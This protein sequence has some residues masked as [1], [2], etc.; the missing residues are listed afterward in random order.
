MKTT[1]LGWGL[2][3]ALL[4]CA[5]ARA[6]LVVYPV[7][8]S[9]SVPSTATVGDTVAISATGEALYSDNSDGNDWNAGDRVTIMRIIIN[10][11][12]PGGSWTTLH[13]WMPSN[14]NPNSIT[15]YLTLNTPGTWYVSFQLMDGRPW[16]SGTPTYAIAVSPP[17]GPTI[18][19]SLN[20]YANQGQYVSYQ[21]TAA[22][23]PTSFGA[24][25]LPP[26]LSINPSNGVISGVQT[27]AS[28]VN[29]TISA[30]N[31]YGTDTKTLTW[32]ITP[33]S[34]VNN[35]TIS[36]NF[37]VNGNSVTLTRDG[38]ANFGVA[39]TQGTIWRPSSGADVLG[40]LPL[41]ASTYTPTDG[42][43]IY[44][45]QYRLIDNY[46]NYQDQWIRLVVTD[47]NPFT[48]SKTSLNFG[49]SVAMN[50]TAYDPSGQMTIAGFIGD[51]GIPGN[52]AWYNNNSPDYFSATTSHSFS[53]TYRP[54]AVG[55]GNHSIYAYGYSNV[56][57]CK[58]QNLVVNKAT[59]NAS[60]SPRTYAPNGGGVYT[61]AAGDLNASFSNP[62][63]G[64]VAA[65]TGGATYTVVGPGTLVQPGTQFGGGTYTIQASYPGD[66]NYN[67]RT[68]TTT[69]TVSGPTVPANVQ[70]STTGSTFVT[71]AWTASSSPAGINHY[72]VYRN[73][74][75]LGTTTSLSYT[76]NT[77]SPSA[78]YSY[79]VQAVDNNNNVSVA[80]TAV[81]VTSANPLEVFT[82][83]P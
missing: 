12:P 77:V 55:S 69:F 38:S 9:I 44:W 29:S 26:G 68:I 46:N 22:N 27:G 17:P 18:S 70:S 50:A 78:S 14:I 54:T 31:A 25:N 37:I 36:P 16:Y 65:P 43:G 13:D 61:I 39:Y 33:A 23:G 79:T 64:A 82:P 81:A 30:S 57:W 73:G 62:Y 6:D 76:D 48:L 58:Y 72:S 71:L 56:W 83:L 20:A 40:N 67:A 66:A 11:L 24:S 60:F 41:G 42:P 63:S 1:F 45:W 19:S 7:F 5:V 49:D 80:S 52:W 8:D 10:Y 74:T 3:L 32:N 34:L 51:A 35:G 28:S 4:S 53:Y 47:M 59:P 75:L 21:I 2:A 15:Q